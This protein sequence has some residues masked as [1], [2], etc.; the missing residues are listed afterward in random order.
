MTLSQHDLNMLAA[1]DEF[2]ALNVIDADTLVWV[3]EKN[4]VDADD[5]FEAWSEE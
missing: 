1:L 2:A 3:A 5:L 4:N